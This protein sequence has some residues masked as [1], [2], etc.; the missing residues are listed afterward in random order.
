VGGDTAIKSGVSDPEAGNTF[1]GYGLLNAIEN[2]FVRHDSFSIGL[3][4]LYFGFGVVER[5]TQERGNET[6]QGARA[7]SRLLSVFFL[8]SVK[9]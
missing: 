5:Q 4:L 2:V 3:H 9:P 8:V 7:K 1:I 6:C